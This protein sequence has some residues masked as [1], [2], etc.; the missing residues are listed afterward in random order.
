M[1]WIF[2]FFWATKTGVFRKKAKETRLLFCDQKE[3]L[4]GNSRKESK[5]ITYY[6]AH[7]EFF[8]KDV[9]SLFDVNGNEQK[10]EIDL[11]Q[12]ETNRLIPKNMR[13]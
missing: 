9:K 12:Y 2:F 8:E 5:N 13:S 4:A 6:K 3:Q 7:S 1:G 10:L 11:L